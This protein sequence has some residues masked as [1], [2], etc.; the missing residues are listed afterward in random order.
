VR[1]GEAEPFPET[2]RFGKPRQLLTLL[3]LEKAL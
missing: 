3:M 2:L 1:T